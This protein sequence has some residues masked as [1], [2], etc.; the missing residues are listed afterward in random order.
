MKLLQIGSIGNEV[1]NLQKQLKDIGYSLPKYGID[2]KFGK[3]TEDAV[4]DFQRK[5]GLK[6]DGIVG[7]ATQAKLNEKSNIAIPIPPAISPIPIPP[8]PIQQQQNFPAI[9]VQI[10]E[11]IQEQT[12]SNFGMIGAIAIGSFAVWKL[13]F[14]KKT[15][16]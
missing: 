9:A 13:F 16:R 4:E 14:A 1:A 15:R 5:N 12:E 7:L 10:P 6:I 2:G 8:A 3:E 11:Q